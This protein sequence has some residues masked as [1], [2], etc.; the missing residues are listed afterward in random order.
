MFITTPFTIAKIGN[1]P[2]CFSA[3]AWIKKMWNIYTVEYY[4]AIK[5][6]EILSFATKLKLE[7]CMLNYICQS[8]QDECYMPPLI[9]DNSNTKQKKKCD[10]FDQN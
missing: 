10:M 4:L 3:D 1:Q 9:C 5:R 6:N 7:A 2:R 8:Q